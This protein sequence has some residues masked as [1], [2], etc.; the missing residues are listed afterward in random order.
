[1][2]LALAAKAG[3]PVPESRVETVSNKPVILLRRFDRVGPQRIPF[4]SAMSMLGAKDR[5]TRSYLEIVDSLRQH[6]AAPK[7]DMQDLWRRIVFNIQISNTDD[8]LRNHGFLY[9]GQAGWRLSPAYDLNPV[10][11]DI[12]PRILTTAIDEDDGTASLDL[13]MSVADYFELEKDM[14]KAITVQ[15]GK[16]VSTWRGEAARHG[17]AKE[18]I[19]RMMSAF[20]HDDLKNARGK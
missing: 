10:P 6:G 19:D 17:V 16:A 3:I 2:A 11:I 18:E 8:H 12:K 14:A 13:A 15:V 7:E 5:D 20:E 1:M 4:L 9:A